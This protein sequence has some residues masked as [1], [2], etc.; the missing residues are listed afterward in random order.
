MKSVLAF[1]AG[2]FIAFVL[3][4]TL[5]YVF[6]GANVSYK[7]WGLICVIGSVSLLIGFLVGA[8]IRRRLPRP[9]RSAGLG[10]AGAIAFVAL[11]VAATAADAEPS[12]SWALLLAL[13][14]LGGLSILLVPRTSP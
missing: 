13:P 4:C 9:L 14:L 3:A 6:W 2:S 8:A 7:V 11:I 1:A 5:S 10:A 12:R